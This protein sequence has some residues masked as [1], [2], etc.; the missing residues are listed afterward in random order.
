M[1]QQ[2]ADSQFR[3]DHDEDMRHLGYRATYT[4]ARVR[5]WLWWH[6]TPNGRY[7]LKCAAR[8]REIANKPIRPET[9]ERFERMAAEGALPVVH[10]SR[11][12]NGDVVTQTKPARGEESTGR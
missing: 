11:N 10:L 7:E 5:H 9:R 1:K 12:E 8:F 6:L 2:P 3:R 4:L